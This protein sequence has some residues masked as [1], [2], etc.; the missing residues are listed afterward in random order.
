MRSF[1]FFFFPYECRQ[2]CMQA[3]HIWLSIAV[4]RLFPLHFLWLCMCIN[5]SKL[6]TWNQWACLIGCYAHLIYLSTKPSSSKVLNTIKRQKI[7]PSDV[8][9]YEFWI[10]RELG[11]H[12]KVVSILFLKLALN[13]PNFQTAVQ[14]VI[15]SFLLNHQLRIWHKIS[16][17]LLAF[18]IS[19]KLPGMFRIH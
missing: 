17:R 16:L 6:P 14:M 15:E 9:L 5:I 18:N 7:F 13:L 10:L 19:V 4:N 12:L 8:F 2:H 11:K 1:F 3:G